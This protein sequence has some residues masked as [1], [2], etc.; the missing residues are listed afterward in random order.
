[1]LNSIKNRKGFYVLDINV[2]SKATGQK[3]ILKI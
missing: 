3:N 2:K 1:M